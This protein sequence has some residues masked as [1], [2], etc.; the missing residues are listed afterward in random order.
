MRVRADHD[1]RATDM[2]KWCR[3]AALF[4]QTIRDPRNVAEVEMRPGDTLLVD[5]MRVMRDFR[6]FTVAGSARFQM[7]R[8]LLSSCLAALST[9]PKDIV[10]FHHPPSFQSYGRLESNQVHHLL[11]TQT[12]YQLDKN[13]LRN[14]K[15]F[16]TRR[17][18]H[19]LPP[20]RGLES[21]FKY[22]RT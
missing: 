9:V 22:R 2:A 10:D 6:G 4:D 7:A 1:P 3:A 14:L 8:L 13:F 17:R 16:K 21:S 15:D 5:N 12:S 20:A 18:R 19:G 11:G